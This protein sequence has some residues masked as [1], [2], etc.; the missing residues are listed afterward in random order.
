MALSIK[1][2][3]TVKP[4]TVKVKEFRYG[5]MAVNMQVI[6]RMTRPMAKVD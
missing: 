5:K 6:G 1:D 4:I 3:G 2:N